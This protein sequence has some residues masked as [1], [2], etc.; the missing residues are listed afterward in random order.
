M[1]GARTRIYGT[2]R[3]LTSLHVG[4]GHKGE[5]AR[6]TETDPESGFSVGLV[7]LDGN[8]MPYIPG[9][10]LKGVLRRL[11]ANPAIL[12][13]PETGALSSGKVI[14]WTA[15]HSGKAPGQGR[16]PYGDAAQQGRDKT[17]RETD[18]YIESQTAIDGEA[19][20]AERSRLF[21]SE[22]V[23][24]GTEFSFSLT[25]AAKL[26]AE[27]EADLAVLLARLCADEGV[28]FGRNT[29]QGKG[30]V[31]LLVDT[32]TEEKHSLKGLDKTATAIWRKN[33][34]AARKTLISSPTCTMTL[35]G[36]GPFL[37]ADNSPRPKAKPGEAAQ[38][39]GLN[40]FEKVG[41]RL[42][43]A[44]LLGALRAKFAWEMALSSGETDES[45]KIF[46]TPEAPTLDTL[47][48]TERLFGVT[49]WRGR[50]SLGAIITD[51]TLKLQ[52]IMSV[53]IDRFSGAPIDNALFGTE[54]WVD[55]VFTVALTL[56]KRKGLTAEQGNFLKA[57]DD[58][59]KTFLE[60]LKCPLWGGLSL[61]LGQNKGYG[62][63]AV[64]VSY[65]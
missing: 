4:S 43:G 17:S 52:K 1:I 53:R 54:A 13:G 12:F 34:N 64:E 58:R 65:G 31:Q 29:R 61:G 49:G 36:S 47:S 35:R 6:D 62:V 16:V 15:L 57:D 20:V 40:A 24:P 56:E 2:L 5:L 63:F 46:G 60:F 10:S 50:V 14:F 42:T 51:E 41:P 38:I 21:H 33:I 19:G 22:Q 7:L 59:F 37:I 25:V 8:G 55:P 26:D 32:I 23:L 45:D 48:T 39:F 3:V 28:G 9:S 27:V 44:S 11:C 18:I 30:R